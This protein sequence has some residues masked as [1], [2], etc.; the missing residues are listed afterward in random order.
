MFDC[1]LMKPPNAKTGLVTYQLRPSRTPFH[2]FLSVGVRKC[3][4]LIDL[5][6]SEDAVTAFPR[7]R[8]MGGGRNECFYDNIPPCQ[9][10]FQNRFCAFFLPYFLLLLLV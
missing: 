3:F 1:M 7:K 9:R 10:R 5:P 4:E 8:G 6:I 2:V